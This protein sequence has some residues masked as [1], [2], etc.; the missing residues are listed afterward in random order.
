MNDKNLKNGSLRA[1]LDGFASAFDLSG[2]TLIAIP[3]L[4]SGFQQDREAIRGDWERLAPRHKY[5]SP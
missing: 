1:F 4:D 5:S 2:Q 3:D